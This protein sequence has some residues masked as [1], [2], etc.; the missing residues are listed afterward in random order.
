MK[1][2]ISRKDRDEILYGKSLV[3]AIRVFRGLTGFG[4]KE[5]HE[6]VVSF[7]EG[8]RRLEDFFRPAHPC[9]HCGGTGFKP[10]EGALGP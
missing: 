2:P 8:G 1:T 6:L 5:A 9:P 4:L 10:E 3:D 7:R